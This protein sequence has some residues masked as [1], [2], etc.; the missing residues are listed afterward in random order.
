LILDYLRLIRT[1]SLRVWNTQK[2]H[3]RAVI[4]QLVAGVKWTTP[5][6]TAALTFDDGPHPSS[7]PDI[8]D[9]LRNS[10]VSA[11]FFCTGKNAQLYPDIVRRIIAEGHA[12]GCHSMVHRDAR[13]ASSFGDVRADHK[14]S[15]RVLEEIVKSPITLYR[16]PH[17]ALTFRTAW[18]LRRS[19]L[20]VWLWT[21][22]PED[23]RPTA[24]VLPIVAAVSASESGDVI[25]MHD[26]IEEPESDEALDRTMTIRSLPSILERLNAKGLSLVSL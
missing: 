1:L 23:W 20:Q 12:V 16:P 17:G 5:E 11:T 15:V 13:T 3:R 14:E 25:L 19:G 21:V 7:T 24:S 18:M 4:C 8:L 6:G 26:W 9:I 10:N 2:G 22:D